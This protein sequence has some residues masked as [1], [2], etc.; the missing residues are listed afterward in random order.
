MI[1][2]AENEYSHEEFFDMVAAWRT[3]HAV[4]KMAIYPP[5]RGLKYFENKRV[6]YLPD[7]VRLEEI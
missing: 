4:N 1:E 7:R 2:F 5:M 6:V 3:R